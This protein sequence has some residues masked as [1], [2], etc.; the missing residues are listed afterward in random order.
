MPKIFERWFQPAM[1]VGDEEFTPEFGYS[2][3]DRRLV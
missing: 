1:T 3:V 2:F